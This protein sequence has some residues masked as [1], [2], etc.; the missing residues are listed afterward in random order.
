L[1]N[2]PA[3]E[4]TAYLKASNTASYANFGR[5]VALDDTAQLAAI[6]SPW[7][8]G[9]SAGINGDPTDQGTDDAGAVY[10]YGFD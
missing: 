7:E 10:V 9:S 2:P 1:R 3:W 6:G 8:D 5:V 4:Q